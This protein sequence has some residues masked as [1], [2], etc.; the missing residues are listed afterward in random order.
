M[1]HSLMASRV[2]FIELAMEVKLCPEWYI[3]VSSAYMRWSWVKSI[4]VL[5]DMDEG[6]WMMAW[7]RSFMK[8]RNSVGAITL[9]CGTPERTW[10]VCD[11]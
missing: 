11:R 5:N 10:P 2:E 1:A 3:I 4:E 8:I 7:L 9:P 6:C